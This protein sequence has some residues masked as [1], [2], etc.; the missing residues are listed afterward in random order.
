[1]F[2]FS[3]KY[4]HCIMNS[5]ASEKNHTQNIDAYNLQASTSCRLSCI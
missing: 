2:M 3:T 4:L 5:G 1:M